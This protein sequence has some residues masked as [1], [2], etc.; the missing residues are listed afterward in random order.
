MV[1]K[2]CSI[3]FDDSYEIF[4]GTHRIQRV[5]ATEKRGRRHTSYV[6]VSKVETEDRSVQLFD[7]DIRIDYY[8][9]SGAGGQHKNKTDSAVRM[10]HI[11]TGIVATA[12]EQRHQHQ[13]RVMA[14]QRLEAKLSRP[15]VDIYTANDVRWEWC[16]WRDEVVLPDGRRKSMARVLKKGV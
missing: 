10:T 1:Q 11:P 13:N 7:S 4:C 2:F 9:A 15:S 5:P 12:T 6:I 8:K 14:R 3:V 16:D